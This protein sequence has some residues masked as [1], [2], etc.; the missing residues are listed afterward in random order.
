MST[1]SATVSVLLLLIAFAVVVADAVLDSV[2]VALNGC[3][4]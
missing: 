4:C 2:A 3:R 1:T